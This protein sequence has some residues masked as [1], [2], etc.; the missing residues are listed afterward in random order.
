MPI[1]DNIYTQKIHSD[2]VVVKTDQEQNHYMF[3]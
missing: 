1:K 3:A 2:V